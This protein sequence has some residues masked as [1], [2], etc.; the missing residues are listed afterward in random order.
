MIMDGNILD[1][2][3]KVPLHL[4]QFYKNRYDMSIDD[5]IILMD[6]RTFIPRALRAE[7]RKHLHLAHRG[8]LYTKARARQSIW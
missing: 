7:S 5:G 4:H 1:N 8:L 3:E 6:G 2:K